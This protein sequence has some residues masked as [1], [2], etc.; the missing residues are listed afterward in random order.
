[1]LLLV[2]GFSLIMI[3]YRVGSQ[4][5]DNTT[6]WPI[7]ISGWVLLVVGFVGYFSF[8]TT[9]L[10]RKHLNKKKNAESCSCEAIPKDDAAPQIAKETTITETK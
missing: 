10:I 8:F 1:V 3:G 5:D 2:A 6:N 4:G 9:V 7:V